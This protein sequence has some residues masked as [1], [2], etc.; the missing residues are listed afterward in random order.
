MPVKRHRYEAPAAGAFGGIATLGVGQHFPETYPTIK[1]LIVYGSPV[2]T[3]VCSWLVQVGPIWVIARL[4]RRE[5]R[6]ALR[7][8]RQICKEAG[9][10][11]LS[12]PAHLRHLQA[13][14][15]RA[16]KL[17]SEMATASDGAIAE[18]F[19]TISI[20]DLMSKATPSSETTADRVAEESEPD[21]NLDQDQPQQLGL[22]DNQ[23]GGSSYAH[24][25]DRVPDL[26]ATDFPATDFPATDFP[27]TGLPAT[28]IK[29]VP[30]LIETQAGVREKRLRRVRTARPE[31]PSRDTTPE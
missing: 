30:T 16:E 24:A 21:N 2:F 26:P 27:A 20:S 12:T 25:A 19:Q 7:R 29:P 9:G 15:E 3:L 13:N 11:P 22:D 1:N 5:M 18:K 23:T 31:K 28:K 14:V 10:N 8:V 6:S 4:K 17:A